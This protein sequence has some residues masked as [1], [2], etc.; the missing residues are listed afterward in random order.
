MLK[1]L[2]Y[3][4]LFQNSEVCV[5]SFTVSD[6]PESFPVYEV[7]P[8]TTSILFRERGLQRYIPLTIVGVINQ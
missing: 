8:T 3:Y 2:F 1:N 4:S 7:L 5:N 6:V